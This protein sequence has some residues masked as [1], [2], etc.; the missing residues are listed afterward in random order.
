MILYWA[1]VEAPYQE[2]QVLMRVLLGLFCEVGVEEA[3]LVE[4][5]QK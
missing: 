3:D 1:V 4:E 2:A 5:E